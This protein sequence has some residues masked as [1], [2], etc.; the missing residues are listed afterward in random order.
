MEE[1]KLLDKSIEKMKSSTYLLELYD[2]NITSEISRF[3]LFIHC[4]K[5]LN[6]AAPNYK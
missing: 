6:K 5:L 1:I 3:N 4:I 2:F